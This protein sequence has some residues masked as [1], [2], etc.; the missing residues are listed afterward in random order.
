VGYVLLD[1]KRKVAASASQPLLGETREAADAIRYNASLA[2]PPGP[3]T[4]RLAVRDGR[5]RLGTVDHHVEA[6]LVRAGDLAL[7]DLFLGRVPEAGRSD[8]GRRRAA[9][10]R[11][12]A[13]GGV[14]PRAVAGAGGEELAGGGDLAVVAHQAQH[15]AGLEA[16]GR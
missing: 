5:G 3:Y 9:V 16:V 14:G 11:A 7:G 2:V 10:P 12:G 1:E 4:L 6:G 8:E 13:L 15:V